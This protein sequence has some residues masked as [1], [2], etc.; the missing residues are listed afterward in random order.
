MSLE[1]FLS[2]GALGGGGALMLGARD[3]IIPLPLSA[4]NGSRKFSFGAVTFGSGSQSQLQIVLWRYAFDGVCNLRV[5][6]R[7]DKE[8]VQKVTALLKAAMRN[9]KRRR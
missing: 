4:L 1:V 2:V 8:D 7:L 3:E 6:R 9:P 5:V